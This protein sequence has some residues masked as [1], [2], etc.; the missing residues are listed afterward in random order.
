MPRILVWQWQD[1]QVRIPFM[2]QL[3]PHQHAIML[4]QLKYVRSVMHELPW[5]KTHLRDLLGS[6]TSKNMTKEQLYPQLTHLNHQ[7]EQEVEDIAKKQQSLALKKQ[8]L[9]TQLSVATQV[10]NDLSVIKYGRHGKP[11]TTTLCYDPG[12][13]TRL[14]WVRKNGGQSTEA[15]ELDVM[16]VQCL[17]STTPLQEMSAAMK[18][19]VTKHNHGVQLGACVSLINTSRTLDLQLASSVQ[20]DWLVSSLHDVISFAQQYKAAGARREAAKAS[21]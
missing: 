6:Y 19:A 10:L 12:V 2:I 15:M 4:R 21:V 16:Q 17:A 13:P 14:C 1:R 3:G 9:T 5:A 20:R 18:K 11:H 7:V 8:R